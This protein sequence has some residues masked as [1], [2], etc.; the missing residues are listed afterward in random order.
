MPGDKKPVSKDMIGAM[1]GAPIKTPLPTGTRILSGR[2]IKPPVK[3]VE[4][5]KK[6][7]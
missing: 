6:K 2:M 1:D 3:P 4:T 7:S 5:G